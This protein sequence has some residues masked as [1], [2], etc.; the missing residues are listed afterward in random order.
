MGLSTTDEAISLTGKGEGFFRPPK[1]FACP[2]KRGHVSG[3][4][5]CKPRPAAKLN[6]RAGSQRWSPVRP[7][8]PGKALRLDSD[9]KRCI[10]SGTVSCFGPWHLS[11]SPTILPLSK[12]PPQAINRQG[13][14][15]HPRCTTPQKLP[16]EWSVFFLRPFMGLVAIIRI[17]RDRKSIWGSKSHCDKPLFL[18]PKEKPPGPL[19]SS[20]SPHGLRSRSE[21]VFD[22][23]CHLGRFV[24]WPNGALIEME[25]PWPFMF[26]PH[27]SCFKKA[28]PWAALLFS[29][30]AKWVVFQGGKSPRW[31]VLKASFQG[32]GSQCLEVKEEPVRFLMATTSSWFPFKILTQKK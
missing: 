7:P 32:T 31:I 9:R 13:K 11:T 6:A 28:P 12:S 10:F 19:S 1:S 18:E 4:S 5:L 8:A 24:F 29:F 3:K 23:K 30:F 2:S 22:L 26:F 16:K 25:K 15:N 27:G 17:K 14:G 20:G 21:D